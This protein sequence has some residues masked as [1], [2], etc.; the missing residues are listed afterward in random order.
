MC[1]SAQSTN[2]DCGCQEAQLISIEASYLLVAGHHVLEDR[3]PLFT[4]SARKVGLSKIEVW[5]TYWQH[6]I[7][8]TVQLWEL[9]QRRRVVSTH[10]LGGLSVWSVL[11]LL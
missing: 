9:D 10:F 3:P 11:P 7:A 2:G 5:A 8:F 6:V 1:P 4:G